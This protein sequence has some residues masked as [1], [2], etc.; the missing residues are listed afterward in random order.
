MKSRAII[1]SKYESRILGDRPQGSPLPSS[2]QATRMSGRTPGRS[3]SEQASIQP[4]SAGFQS[5]PLRLP[6]A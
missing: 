1:H 5:Q 4:L 2:A 6:K 3:A